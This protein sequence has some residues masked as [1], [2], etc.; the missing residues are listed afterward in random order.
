MSSV[1]NTGIPDPGCD[2]PASWGPRGRSKP[3]VYTHPM[4]PIIYLNE[5][6][7]EFHRRNE[8]IKVPHKKHPPETTKPARLNFQPD[9]KGAQLAFV[10]FW[11]GQRP[12][13]GFPK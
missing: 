5:G 7:C 3:Y 4:H 13:P 1:Y 9:L 11:E 8:G 2:E 6:I 10:F 12:H